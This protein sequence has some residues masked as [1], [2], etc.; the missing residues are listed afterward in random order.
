M[1]AAGS[2]VLLI[3]A[4]GAGGRPDGARVARQAVSMARHLIAVPSDPLDRLL[5]LQVEVS[6]GL[7]EASTVHPDAIAALAVAVITDRRVYA[8]SIGDCRVAVIGGDGEIRASTT[9]RDGLTRW[10][11]TRAVASAAAPVPPQTRALLLSY[12][13]S[14]SPT[15]TPVVVVDHEAADRVVVTSDGVHDWLPVAELANVASSHRAQSA[16]AVITSAAIRE[17][18]T[19]NVTAAIARLGPM[20]GWHGHRLNGGCA[21]GAGQDAARR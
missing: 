19:D 15:P 8:A 11:E 18:S 9:D 3:V 20:P 1:G 12:V 10:L 6:R 7:R 21:S 5:R 16:A 13:P 17:G 4:D 14:A 2:E